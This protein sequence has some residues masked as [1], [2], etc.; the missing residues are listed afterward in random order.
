MLCGLLQPTAGTATVG[1][2]DIDT[3]T[4]QVKQNIGYMSQRFS[5]YDDL[6][7]EQNIR[8]FGG[9][10]GL[11]DRRLAGADGLGAGDGG[12]AGTGENA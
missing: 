7:V 2:Y 4:E 5:L 1:G 6:T 3:Q 12:P 9:V 10:Y 11:A 8:F